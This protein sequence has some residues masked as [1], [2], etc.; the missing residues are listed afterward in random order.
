MIIILLLSCIPLAVQP[1]LL[2]TM[3]AAGKFAK[4]CKV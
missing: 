2:S 4:H 3:T 1:D